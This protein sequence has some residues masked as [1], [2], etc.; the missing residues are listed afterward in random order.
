VGRWS[1]RE[2]PRACAYCGEALTAPRPG[3]DGDRVAMIVVEHPL[4]RRKVS[5]GWHIGEEGD[6]TGGHCYDVSPFGDRL[7]VEDDG[8]A[9]TFTM[10]REIAKRGPNRVRVLLEGET[11]VDA[12][13]RL[14]GPDGA[15]LTRA[16][17]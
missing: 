2:Y 7:V 11:A 4:T 8:V 1:L 5:V 3:R 6:A 14:L 17:A 10:I 15:A 13:G 12:R 9:F 16:I